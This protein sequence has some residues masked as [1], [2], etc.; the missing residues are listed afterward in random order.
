MSR[1]IGRMLLA[2]VA[3]A[4]TL[5][6]CEGV[7]SLGFRKSLRPRPAFDLER[8]FQPGAENAAPINGIFASNVDPAVAHTLRLNAELTDRSAKFH[9]DAIGLRARSLP[10]RPEQVYE[11]L[12]KMKK[13]P[14]GWT[15]SW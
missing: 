4:V 10:I 3:V 13:A 12:R 6:L 7:L 5:L 11:H 2:I 8:M 1:V 9:T 14:G 15:K